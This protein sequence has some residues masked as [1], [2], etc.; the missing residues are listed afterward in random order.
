MTSPLAGRP[1]YRM[2][3]IG[4]EIL[5][6]DLRGADLTVAPAEARAIARA[7]GLRFDQLMVLH[8]PR[9]TGADAF[10]RIYNTDGSLSSAC[11]NGTRCVAY[12][13]GR[14]GEGDAL[15]L[16]TDAGPVRTWRKGETRFTVDMGRPRL[17]W[18]EIPLAA[19]A[20]DT[21]NVPL[22][23]AVQGAPTVFSAANMGNP[24]AVFFVD[25]PSAVDLATLGPQLEHHPL[26]PERANISFAK[27][28]AADD[29]LLRVWERGTGE[30]RAC[31]SAACAVLVAA[32]RAG[33]SAREARVRL[34]G[35]D[36]VIAWGP[37]DHVLMT[38][39]VELE[40]ETRL[41]A[42][43]FDEQGA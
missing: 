35:G 5:V 17:G 13:L 8:E 3:G 40:F 24:H 25:D 10:M 11:G 20:P 16:E 12:I 33:L 21:S 31:G 23:P 6:L 1:I 41:E 9:Q 7:P 14:A 38:G 39:D 2:N 37:D 26:F 36:L 43:V 4:N 27:V 29:I 30:T 28:V 42:R 19:A 22:A 18:R 32:A 15:T 34:P